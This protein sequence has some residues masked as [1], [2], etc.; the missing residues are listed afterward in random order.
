MTDQI[1]TTLLLVCGISAIIAIVALDYYVRRHGSLFSGPP[2]MALRVLAII[3]GFA[4]VALLFYQLQVVWLVLSI[5]LLAYGFGSGDLLHRLQG[6]KQSEDNEISSTV[7]YSQNSYFVPYRHIEIRSIW[8]LL[9]R[10]FLIL[11]SL[12]AV[13]YSAVWLVQ[14]PTVR[15]PVILVGIIA[16]F[17]ISPFFT[18]FGIFALGS[19][20]SNNA[21]TKKEE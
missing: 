12:F 9:R 4:F 20:I 15:D 16:A 6:T 19:H 3:L 1:I 10:W 21:S 8:S 14:H 11:G 7:S 13:L 2:S 18:I 17:L 5:S